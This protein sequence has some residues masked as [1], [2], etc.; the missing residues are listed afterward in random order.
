LRF[1]RLLHET[2]VIGFQLENLGF[3]FGLDGLLLNQIALFV[4]AGF[5]K[6]ALLRL[7]GGRG[8]RRLSS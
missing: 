7:P 1:R 6:D 5:G 3:Q 8:L 2:F 4:A